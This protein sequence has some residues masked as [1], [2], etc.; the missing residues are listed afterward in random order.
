MR[1][2]CDA[3]AGARALGGPGT[4]N[5]ARLKSGAWEA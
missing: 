4:L 5:A 3:A 1:T 2:G